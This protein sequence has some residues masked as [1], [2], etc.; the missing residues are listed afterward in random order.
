MCLGL[1]LLP[2]NLIDLRLVPRLK[3]SP[4]SPQPSPPR[5][6]SIARRLTEKP[7]MVL[8]ARTLDDNKRRLLFPLP[9]GEG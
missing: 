7:A 6:G 3:R 9:E 8:A 1:N 5:R 4:P 2:M